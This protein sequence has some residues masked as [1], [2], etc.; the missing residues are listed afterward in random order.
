MENGPI[1]P[2]TAATWK[3]STLTKGLLAKRVTNY[4]DRNIGKMDTENQCITN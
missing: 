2:L 4:L 1:F 3:V